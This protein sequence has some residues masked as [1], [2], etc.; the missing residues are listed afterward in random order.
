MIPPF[1]TRGNL[2]PG[3]HWTTWDEVEAR[4]GLNEHRQKLLVGLNLAIEAL[5][6][7]GC[8][9]IYINGSFVTSKELPGDFDACW[10]IENVDPYHL[11]PV[12]LTF[13]DRRAAQKAKYLGELF[14][15][16]FTADEVGNVFLDFFQRDREGNAKGLV[17]LRLEDVR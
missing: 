11:D 5:Q 2:P 3:I 12:L 4:F 13:D 8:Q 9:A 6:L 16:Q 15:A 7:A 14:P 1:D 10:D 17:A